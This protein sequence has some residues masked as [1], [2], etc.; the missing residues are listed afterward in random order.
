MKKSGIPVKLGRV[1]KQPRGP[2]VFVCTGKILKV[3]PLEN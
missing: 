2:K 1:W 3:I